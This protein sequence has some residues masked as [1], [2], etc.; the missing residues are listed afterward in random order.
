MAELSSDT[1]LFLGQLRGNNPKFAH[2]MREL[3][4]LRPVVPKYVPQDTR[5][6]ESQLL[7]RIKFETAQQGGF[8]LLYFILTGDRNE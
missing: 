5:D 8:D 2:V 3:K 1:K 4:K 7:E 6:A